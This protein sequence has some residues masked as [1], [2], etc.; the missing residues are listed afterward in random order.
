MWH[1]LYSEKF[2][3]PPPQ[4]DFNT[5]PKHNEESGVTRDCDDWS[6]QIDLT[7]H[8]MGP[9]AQGGGGVSVPK[10]RALLRTW[11]SLSKSVLSYLAKGG[12]SGEEGEFWEDLR[13]QVVVP[14]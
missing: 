5:E 13:W 11:M 14:G 2:I 6:V 8:P 12:R 7:A 4:R 9:P 10:V 3:P 1:F